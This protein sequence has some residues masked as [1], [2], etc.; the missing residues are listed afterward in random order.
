MSN[1]GQ[2]IDKKIMRLV[3]EFEKVFDDVEVRHEAH[4]MTTVSDGASV[5]SVLQAAT[6]MCLPLQQEISAS[7]CLDCDH[8][9][10]S[11]RAADGSLVLRCWTHKARPRLG[12]GTKTF[13][14]KKHH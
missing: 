13:E 7:L 9:I 1:A 3:E 8:F 14:I 6:T 2:N 11:Q 10:G 12:R 4:M 5:S